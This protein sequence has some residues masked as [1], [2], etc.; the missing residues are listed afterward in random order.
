MT[1]T[2]SGTGLFAG[3]RIER[4][5]GVGG[6]GEVFL[7]A[8][9]DLPR[10]VALKV[11]TAPEADTSGLR[12][13]FLREADTAAQLNHPN[14]VTVYARGQEGDR[15]WIAM[16]YVEGSD[17]A[18]LVRRGPLPVP[19]AVH[20]VT[21]IAKA[22]DYAHQRGVIH[23][24]VKPANILLTGA[25]QV[26]LADFGIAK[27]TDHTDGLTRT[28]EVITSFQYAAPEL[29]DHSGPVDHR[30]DV[31]ALGCT[32]YHLLTG[33]PPFAGT[34]PAQLIH[35]HLAQPVPRASHHFPWVPAAFDA[36]LARALAKDPAARFQS[37]GELAAAAVGAMSGARLPAPRPSRSRRG[38]WLSLGALGL[39]TALGVATAAV[40]LLRGESAEPENP[41]AAQEAARLAACEF[42]RVIGT[43]HYQDID[44]YIATVRAK[45]TGPFLDEFT[46]SS[47]TLKSAMQN[48]QVSSTIDG[49]VQCLSKSGADAEFLVVDLLTQK[50]TS[51]NAPEGKQ[52]KM[53]IVLTMRKVGDRWLCAELETAQ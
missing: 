11:I 29:F 34:S 27:A 53:T 14:I 31:Y 35:G 17:A 33:A 37:C 15:L 41:M 51:L 2:G 42:G 36:V 18:E 4:R 32:L 46:G 49:E 45:S 12:A 38:L 48:T 39:V 6:M 52:Q 8:D 19:Q 26:L 23:R 20:I 50:M 7:A 10:W 9:R 25:D 21:Q 30:T 43:Y 44:S 1:E 28:G 5:L 22:L 13:R 16:Q 24:D 40:I 3:Y 47:E